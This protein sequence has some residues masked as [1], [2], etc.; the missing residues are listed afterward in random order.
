MTLAPAQPASPDWVRFKFL[1]ATPRLPAFTILRVTHSQPAPDWVR[2]KF[3]AYSPIRRA[4][5]THQPTCSPSRADPTP[6]IRRDLH[7]GPVS[8]HTKL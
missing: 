3:L 8:R 2:F 6:L 7:N 5:E 4:G 1:Q